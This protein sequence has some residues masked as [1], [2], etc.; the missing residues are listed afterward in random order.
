MSEDKSRRVHGSSKTIGI[1]QNDTGQIRSK[2]KIR[3]QEFKPVKSDSGLNSALSL[4]IFWRNRRSKWYKGEKGSQEERE[5][6][7]A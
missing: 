5:R 4:S 3:K 2:I 1:L 7:K 6:T